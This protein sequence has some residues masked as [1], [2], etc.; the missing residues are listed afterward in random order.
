ME[1]SSDFSATDSLVFIM[2]L[3]ELVEKVIMA[4]EDMMTWFS[5]TYIGR[6]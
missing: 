1:P 3:S 4:D 6:N 2:L 5:F